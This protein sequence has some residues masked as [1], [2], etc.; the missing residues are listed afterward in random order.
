[1]SASINQCISLY[2]K[3]R[4]QGEKY[5]TKTIKS[6]L[7]PE[8]PIC[9]LE[10][11]DFEFSKPF[12]DKKLMDPVAYSF[13]YFNLDQEICIYCNASSFGNGYIGEYWEP[14]TPHT[15]TVCFAIDID[16]VFWG[17]NRKNEIPIGMC[18]T[19]EIHDI[20]KSV[21][22]AYDAY[23][24]PVYDDWDGVLFKICSSNASQIISCGKDYRCGKEKTIKICGD[25][26]K[27]LDYGFAA[28]H[29][30]SKDW[31]NCN[32]FFHFRKL[33]E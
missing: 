30:S 20:A 11:Y 26:L 3:I 16:M 6:F 5:L 7:W 14:R 29:R 23:H 9:H 1:M 28:M 15:I 31:T 21:K 22:R 2:I 19:R 18:L 4:D 12:T 24:Q 10:R 13:N 33:D 8:C 17:P 27:P 32:L 25:E